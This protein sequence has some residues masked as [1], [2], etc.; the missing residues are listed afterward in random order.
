MTHQLYKIHSSPRKPF[1]KT[2][3]T[4]SLQPRN[5]H[6]WNQSLL[7][8]T[9]R[10]SHQKLSEQEQEVKIILHNQKPIYPTSHQRPILVYLQIHDRPSQHNHSHHGDKYN[11]HTNHPTK[12]R[13]CNKNSEQ[14][15]STR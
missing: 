3:R 5:S 6:L 13:F 9:Y 15:T 7:T 2:P 14:Y 12:P 8:D 1:P 11:R 4:R 10:T